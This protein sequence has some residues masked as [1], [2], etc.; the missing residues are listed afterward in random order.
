[1]DFEA[2]LNK[3]LKLLMK[4]IRRTPIKKISP[5]GWLVF[6]ITGWNPKIVALQGIN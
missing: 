1:M 6:I 4:K 5:Q 2:D 3:K